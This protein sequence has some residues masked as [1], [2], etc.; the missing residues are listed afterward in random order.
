M[1]SSNVRGSYAK[2]H[3]WVNRILTKTGRCTKCRKT[4]NTEWSNKSGEYKHEIDDW[5]ELCKK[6]HIE[7][8]KQPHMRGAASRFDPSINCKVQITVPRR[9]DEKYLKAAAKKFRRYADDIE[10]NPA[11]LFIK[12]VAELPGK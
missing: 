11:E 10:M 12:I 2:I 4:G 6:C 7:Y 5:Q 9:T 3:S 1:A 8:D